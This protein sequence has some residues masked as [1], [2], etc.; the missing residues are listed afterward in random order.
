MFFTL[1][2]EFETYSRYLRQAT[3]LGE[4]I[5][6]GARRGAHVGVFYFLLLRNECDFNQA[7]VR[8]HRTDSDE[9]H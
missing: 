2:F 1:H 4:H 5:D 8:F 6:E 3:S 7:V 9:Y